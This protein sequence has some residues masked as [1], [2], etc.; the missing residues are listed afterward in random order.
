[1][2]GCLDYVAECGGLLWSLAVEVADNGLEDCG[3][4]NADIWPEK[5]AKLDKKR[6]SV[7]LSSSPMR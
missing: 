6:H 1:M 5:S 3:S 2:V 7:Q 4:I